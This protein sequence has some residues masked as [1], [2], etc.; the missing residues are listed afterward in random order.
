M[1]RTCLSRF[2]LGMPSR[3]GGERVAKMGALSLTPAT[4]SLAIAAEWPATPPLGEWRSSVR[5]AVLAQLAAFIEPRRAELDNT[6]VDA[7]GDILMT[8]ASGGK[9][10]RSTF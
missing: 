8:F 5:H 3:P 1:S 10:L 6:S 7:A 9:C 4:E 2:S